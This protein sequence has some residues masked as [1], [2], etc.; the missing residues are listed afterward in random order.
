MNELNVEFIL[1]EV[2]LA[3]YTKA[4]D[5]MFK[6]EAEE[7]KILKKIIPSMGGSHIGIC[8]LRATY[9]QCNKYCIIG[10]LYTADPGRKVTIKRNLK[11]DVTEGIIFHR[12]LFEALLGHN[13][14]L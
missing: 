9:K 8:M 14:A 10:L 12:K 4:V 2:D 5:V 7:F 13:V 11:G 1:L 3:I 6:M